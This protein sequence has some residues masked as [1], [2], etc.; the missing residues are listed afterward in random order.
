MTMRARPGLVAVAISV[1]LV[2]AACSNDN[3]TT[4]TTSTSA[5]PIAVAQAR[6]DDAQTAVSDAENALTSAHQ[7][8]CGTATGYVEILDRYGRV[9]TDRAATVG[10]VQT[11]GADLIAPREEVGGPAQLRERD[12]RGRSPGLR[13]FEPCSAVHHGR[14][15][16]RLA[17]CDVEW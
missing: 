1:A 8:F 15:P 9:F 6:V 13:P 14:D 12:V 16:R 17:A 5:D 4:P 2:T 10:D 3:G 7:T 11:L